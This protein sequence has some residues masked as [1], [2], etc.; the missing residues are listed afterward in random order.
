[1]SKGE[2]IRMK[3]E[4]ETLPAGTYKLSKLEINS[5]ANLIRAKSEI[6]NGKK[7][8]EEHIKKMDLMEKM[9]AKDER[10]IHETIAKAAGVELGE[11]VLVPSKDLTTFT[12]KEKSDAQEETGGEKRQGLNL[13]D[14]QGRPLTE[15][16]RSGSLGI[17]TPEDAAALV[18]VLE[19]E[20]D[21]R[22]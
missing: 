13:L 5:L 6:A 16:A 7:Q 9:R 1:M 10:E 21:A 8:A 17:R 20:A 11:R 15:A 19:G 12:I 2:R 4:N 22:A 18:A 14:S 3:H